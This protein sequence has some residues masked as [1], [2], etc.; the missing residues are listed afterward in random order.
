MNGERWQKI[1]A[2]FHAALNSEPDQR[3]EFLARIRAT[4]EALCSEVESLLASHDQTDSFFE[5]SAS[6]LAAEMLG[7]K[8][9][10]TIGPY[11]VIS[12]LGAGGMGEVYLAEDSSARN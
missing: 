5:N 11:Q 9:G 2:L 4:D 12:V 8:E 1:E 3:T 7:G 6:A 10:E